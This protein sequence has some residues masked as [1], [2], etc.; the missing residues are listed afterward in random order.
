MDNDFIGSSLVF[1]LNTHIY[2]YNSFLDQEFELKYS[3]ESLIYIFNNLN[4]SFVNKFLLNFYEECIIEHFG[5]VPNEIKLIIN[6]NYINYEQPA[7]VVD[8]TN[9]TS[10]KLINDKK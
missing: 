7:L 2:F 3:L 4:Y 10:K 9:Y 8:K 1:F 5:S 6:K